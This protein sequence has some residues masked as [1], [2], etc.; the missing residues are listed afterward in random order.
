[1]ELSEFKKIMHKSDWYKHCPVFKQENVRKTKKGTFY[2]SDLDHELQR[3]HR[4]FYH[5]VDYERVKDLGI[6]STSFP[7]PVKEYQYHKSS[8]RFKAISE[9]WFLLEDEAIVESFISKEGVEIQTAKKNREKL[10]KERAYRRR[11][12]RDSLVN[13]FRKI[14]DDNGINYCVNSSMRGNSIYVTV[15]MEK[16]RFSDHPPGENHTK[17]CPSRGEFVEVRYNAKNIMYKKQLEQIKE[18]I[19]EEKRREK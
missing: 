2:I 7:V 13:N 19:L 12:K 11:E 17:F 15:D 4:S 9:L 18:E 10:E 3:I 6:R 16:Y 14:L 8:S 1:M 5:C